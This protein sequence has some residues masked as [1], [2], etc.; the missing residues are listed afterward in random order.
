M[1]YKHLIENSGYV[2]SEIRC[3]ACGKFNNRN[4]Q[5]VVG[6]NQYRCINCGS[7]F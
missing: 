1:T 7:F 6:M 2:S 4:T 3:P 5:K